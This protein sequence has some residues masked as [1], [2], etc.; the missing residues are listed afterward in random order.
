MSFD[1]G[2][3]ARAAIKYGKAIAHTVKMFRHISET[4]GSR[5]FELEV[6]VDDKPYAAYQG[7]FRLPAGGHDLKIRATDTAGN[8]SQMITGE[9]VSGGK[10]DR[11]RLE[12]R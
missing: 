3:L 1:E 8:R 10:T 11:I 7:P 12:I 9:A 5:P 6:S 2:G 4:M